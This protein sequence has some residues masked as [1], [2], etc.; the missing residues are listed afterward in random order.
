[1]IE[2]L[3]VDEDTC[4]EEDKYREC[5]HWGLAAVG[6]EADTMTGLIYG[7]CRTR[8]YAFQRLQAAKENAQKIEVVSCYIDDI[9]RREFAE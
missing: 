8:R 9:L 1:M 2:C 4:L 7:R 5:R 6:M 3:M